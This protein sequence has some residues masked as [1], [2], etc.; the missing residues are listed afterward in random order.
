MWK[1]FSLN[2]KYGI[3]GGKLQHKHPIPWVPCN[4]RLFKEK[5]RVAERQTRLAET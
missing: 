5:R 4:L 2:A 1:N 3:L